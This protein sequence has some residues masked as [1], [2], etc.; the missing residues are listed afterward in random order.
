MNA[1]PAGDLGCIRE[2]GPARNT[3]VSKAIRCRLAIAFGL[4]FSGC[5]ESSVDR[6]V[7]E[8]MQ[9]LMKNTQAASIRVRVKPVQR[10]SLTRRKSALPATCEIPQGVLTRNQVGE[11]DRYFHSIR[12]WVAGHIIRSF[13]DFRYQR[14]DRERNGSRAAGKRR[15]AYHLTIAPGRWQPAPPP[16]CGRP[17]RQGS[18][19]LTHA[20][21]QVESGRSLTS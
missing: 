21:Q 17:P 8:Q 18:V 7:E 19:V 1:N 4:S 10:C 12:C 16:L 20:P 9:Y 15:M 14:S 6:C 5:A 2:I 3:V 13:E 11:P